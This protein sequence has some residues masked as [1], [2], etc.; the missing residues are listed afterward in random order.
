MDLVFCKAPGQELVDHNGQ[1]I[2]NRG[3]VGL[4]RVRGKKRMRGTGGGNIC[5]HA[6]PGDFSAVRRRETAFEEGS[7]PNQIMLILLREIL[8]W[9]ARAGN[10]DVPHAC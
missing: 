5:K 8:R 4:A 7:L 6:L 2:L 9:I 3:I 10:N 1:A